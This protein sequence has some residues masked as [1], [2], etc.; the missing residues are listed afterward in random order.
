MLSTE[1]LRRNSKFAADVEEGS[2]GN[3]NPEVG[4]SFKA[5]EGAQYLIFLA[6]FIKVNSGWNQEGGQHSTMVR[7]HASGPSCPGFDSHRR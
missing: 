3:L 2:V 5:F 4:N 7:I 1:K 6:R